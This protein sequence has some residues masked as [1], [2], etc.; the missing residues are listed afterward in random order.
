MQK[1]LLMK[2]RRKSRGKIVKV[3]PATWLSGEALS[4]SCDSIVIRWLSHLS[5]VSTQELFGSLSAACSLS[6]VRTVSKPH[7]GSVGCHEWEM[8]S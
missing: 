8:Q 6:T 2:K 1:Q 5:H 3:M 7:F 4:T